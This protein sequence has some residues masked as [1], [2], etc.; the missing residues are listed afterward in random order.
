MWGLR[1]AQETDM[2]C[3][4]AAG[5]VVAGDGKRTVMH[6]HRDCVFPSGAPWFERSGAFLSPRGP[7]FDRG[8]A[9]HSDTE[10][11]VFS[12]FFSSPLSVPFHQRS[13]HIFIYKLL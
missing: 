1:E 8:C 12:P 6:P 4:Q 10:T 3:R 13:T 9:G 2:T 5:L 7:G 11:G